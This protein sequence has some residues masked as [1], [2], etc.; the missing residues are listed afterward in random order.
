MEKLF[1]CTGL[2]LFG[3]ILGSFAGATVWRLRARQLVVDKADGEPVDKKE[4]KQLLP[5]A[6]ANVTDDR[7]QCLHCGHVLA[8]YDLLPLVSWTSTG[9]K[10]RYCHQ[11]IGWFEPL[12]ELGL[13]TFFVVSYLFW[14]GVL[15]TQLEIA[16]FFLWLAAGVIF[17]ILFAYD[18]KWFL[19]PNTAVFSLIGVGMLVA[20]LHVLGVA[21]KLT[22]LI[23][24][25][26]AIAILS[27]LYLAL[28]LV[29]KGQWIGLGDVKLGL[30]LA[31][32]LGRWEL[33][34]I[35]L[36]SANLIGCLIVLPAMLRGKVTR[37]THVPF[38]PLLIAGTVLAM[39]AGP[40]IID[41][42]FAMYL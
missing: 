38:G 22:A 2:A 13:A 28:W 6:K 41:W 18:L 26:V 7:S 23:S 5:L 10:C 34:F 16:P 8:W 32:L 40:F 30:G 33:A 35:A 25:I 24:L 36:F 27:G 17:A 11:P 39:L 29:S 20:L 15:H 31:L 9:G 19:L 14:P 37:K 1:I 42:Y 12:I 3:L 21:D 4:Y